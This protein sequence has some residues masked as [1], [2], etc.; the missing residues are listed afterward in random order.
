MNDEIVKTCDAKG[1]RSYREVQLLSSNLLVNDS[2]GGGFVDASGHVYSVYKNEIRIDPQGS[3]WVKLSLE[4]GNYGQGLY[5]MI[6]PYGMPRY[7]LCYGNYEIDGRLLNYS[8]NADGLYYAQLDPVLHH[9]IRDYLE[10]NIITA[11]G[12]TGFVGYIHENDG[13]TIMIMP[14]KRVMDTSNDVYE[15]IR[16]SFVRYDNW[17][18]P[19]QKVKE[20]SYNKD[21]WDGYNYG[22]ALPM[23]LYIFGLRGEPITLTYYKYNNLITNNIVGDRLDVEGYRKDESLEFIETVYGNNVVTGDNKYNKV[24]LCEDSEVTKNNGSIIDFENTY[25]FIQEDGSI[26]YQISANTSKIREFYDYVQRQNKDAVNKYGNSSVYEITL[27]GSIPEGYEPID[28]NYFRAYSDTGCGYDENG[29]L[30]EYGK[31]ERGSIDISS[32]FIGHSGNSLITVATTSSDSRIV[33]GTTDNFYKYKKYSAFDSL[34]SEYLQDM[35]RYSASTAFS[36]GDHRRHLYETDY[37]H[38]GHNNEFTWIVD[39]NGS[40]STKIPDNETAYFVV[41]PKSI[42]KFPNTAAGIN[43]V[44]SLLDLQVWHGNVLKPIYENTAV[45]Y[46]N[47]PMITKNG[48]LGI[49]YGTDVE[50]IHYSISLRTYGTG[51]IHGVVKL[52]DDMTESCAY[53]TSATGD[54][55]HYSEEVAKHTK[56]NDSIEIQV[57]YPG[58]GSKQYRVENIREGE[59]WYTL[60]GELKARIKYSGDMNDGLDITITPLDGAEYVNIFY[61]CEFDAAEYA[62]AAHADGTVQTLFTNGVRYDYDLFNDESDVI[63]SRINGYAFSAQPDAS[64]KWVESPDKE[65]GT[66]K[67]SYAGQLD[68]GVSSVPEAYLAFQINSADEYV[69]GELTN[70]VQIHELLPYLK[71]EN[72][73]ISVGNRRSAAGVESLY[74]PEESEVYQVGVVK[75]PATVLKDAP[76]P[77]KDGLTAQPIDG[78]LLCLKVTRKD[79]Q[80]IDAQ[81][82]FDI[83][84]DLVLD[85]GFRGISSYNGGVLA[86]SPQL[87]ICYPFSASGISLMSAKNDTWASAGAWVANTEYLVEPDGKKGLLDSA[88]NSW[89]LRY[90]TGSA[91]KENPIDIDLKDV[92]RTYAEVNGELV[93]EEKNQKLCEEF[94]K[95]MQVV[96]DDIYF[97]TPEADTKYYPKEGVVPETPKFTFKLG[98]GTSVG[99]EGLAE[100]E[101][102][103]WGNSQILEVFGEDVP[104]NSEVLVHYHF[105]IDWIALHKAAVAAGLINEEDEI[106]FPGYKNSLDDGRGIEQFEGKF[107]N[108]V[109]ALGTIGKTAEADWK[110]NEITWTVDLTAGGDTIS[111]FVIQ[112]VLAP[113][114]RKTSE[115]TDNDKLAFDNMKITEFS[116]LEVSDSDEETEIYKHTGAFE[117]GRAIKLADNTHWTGAE[118]TFD[119]DTAFSIK[120]DTYSAGKLRIRYKTKLDEKA[121]VDAGGSFEEGYSVYNTAAASAP[122]VKIEANKSETF[123]NPGDKLSKEVETSEAGLASEREWTLTVPLH[124]GYVKDVNI[125][126]TME[127]SPTELMK[128]MSISSMKVALVNEEG[129]SEKIYDSSDETDTLAEHT[130]VFEEL[131]LNEVGSTGFK[132]HFDE[133][134]AG[135]KVV[136][137]YSTRVDED[138]YREAVKKDDGTGDFN[139]K[140]QY[141]VSNEAKFSQQGWVES[142]TSE[143]TTVKIEEPVYKSGSVYTKSGKDQNAI[144]QWDVYVHLDS[145]AS[146]EELE[147]AETATI[148]DSLP[149]GLKWVEDYNDKGANLYV[150][151]VYSY[152]TNGWTYRSEIDKAEYEVAADPENP[153]RII[154]TLKNPSEHKHI[155]VR[156]RTEAIANLGS[157]NNSVSVSVAGSTKSD[158]SEPVDNVYSARNGGTVVSRRLPKTEL[159][160][161][162]TVNGETPEET[163]KFHAEQVENIADEWVPVEKGYSEDA[164][165]DADGKVKFPETGFLDPGDYYFKISEVPDTDKDSIYYEGTA[166]N[167]D[168]REYIVH[169]QTYLG[170]NS[171]YVLQDIIAVLNGDA[172]ISDMAV[173][174]FDNTTKEL[175]EVTVTKVW[176]DGLGTLRPEEIEV[177]LW[178]NDEPYS[179]LSG[180]TQKLSEDNEWTYTWSDLPANGEYTVKEL[181]GFK[182]SIYYEQGDGSVET[183]GAKTTITLENKIKL[184]GLDI[185]KEVKG[186]D[187]ETDREWNFKIVFDD[188][189]LNDKYGDVDIKNGEGTFKLKHGETV[190]I[191]DIP[192]GTKYEITEVE[193]NTDR[194]KTKSENEAGEVLPDEIVKVTFENKRNLSLLMPST[195]GFGADRWMMCSLVVCLTG[196]MMIGYDRRKRKYS[197][198]SKN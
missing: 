53:T 110:A 194:Y 170:D 197:K 161:I 27:N 24:F 85:E 150:A 64:L 4:P 76:T 49:K 95:H 45:A 47:Y 155:M 69:N 58:A 136:L 29:L 15:S 178:R 187:G 100:P 88:T 5:S 159:E 174:E 169:A 135:Y 72:V 43:S 185:T 90:K 115:F 17:Y 97:G 63:Y 196:V 123:D 188:K 34:R 59:Y 84:F 87:S 143:D 148:V 104:I 92:L 73:H 153:Q 86:L 195:G 13:R 131:T 119:S 127:A 149:F 173:P 141:T 98:N 6:V 107:D 40:N 28:H 160:A 96:V 68:V 167:W 146:A 179:S 57:G 180:Y 129:A 79:G 82:Y 54:V 130:G 39:S 77:E 105:K 50:E 140:N 163:F 51:G 9:E 26:R 89:E 81:T 80:P 108:P 91:G 175:Q 184:S 52:H 139:S 144:V 114:L 132:L 192:A 138:A 56:M 32:T 154:I 12:Y 177:Q 158:W 111:D 193:A 99:Y 172:D 128:F 35:F 31:D 176:T 182:N 109:E 118:L 83:T 151:E 137:T 70:N 46:A 67:N 133:L 38:L 125:S 117:A 113:G 30:K 142:D 78:N 61:V 168:T 121:F 3:D 66:F 94:F 164:E 102:H 33:R 65:Q 103:G 157:T 186:S 101:K 25:G 1:Y 19:L 41:Y 165:T 198:A 181:D 120:T 48:S 122:G 22:D 44:P 42:P 60:E 124:G 189:T 62:A 2:V 16:S 7:G 55:R 162:K 145:I 93:D 106:T 112:D 191:K 166:Y 36:L 74:N 10:K 75:N 116:I 20:S 190:H 134:D 18:A 71:L 183:G 152:G 156:I 8:G 11:Y 23:E 37:S 126:D 14:S 147:S 21:S 171:Y